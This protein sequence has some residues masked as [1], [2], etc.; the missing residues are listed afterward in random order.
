MVPSLSIKIPLGT[1]LN[2]NKLANLFSESITVVK[3]LSCAYG[4]A[5]SAP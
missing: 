3:D 1:I 5:T 2:P 4:F